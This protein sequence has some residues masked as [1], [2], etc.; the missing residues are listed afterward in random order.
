[1][2]VV[3]SGWCG[4]K[5]VEAGGNLGHNTHHRHTGPPLNIFRSPTLE[6]KTRWLACSTCTWAAG[7]QELEGMDNQRACHSQLSKR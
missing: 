5:L 7:V 4:N 3:G 1:M 2:E 6:R